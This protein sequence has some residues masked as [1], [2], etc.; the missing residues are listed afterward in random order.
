M[1]ARDIEKGIVDS[2]AHLGWESFKEDRDDVIKRAFDQGISQIV[3]AGVDFVS[4]PECLEIAE[5]YANI[6]NGVGLHPHEAKHWNADSA[7]VVRDAFR[8]PSVVAI[9]ECGLDYFYNHSE[10][11][12]QLQVFR[13]QV[14]L[15]REL[16]K[17]LIIHTRDAW[18][19]TFQ[20]IH[21]EGK[22]EVKGVFHCFTGGPA[23]MP[24][25]E[26]IDFY[27]SFSGIVTFK[28]SADIQAAAPMVKPSRI[29]VETDSPYLAPEGKRGKRNEPSF[30]WITAQKLATLRATDLSEIAEQTSENA[31][32]LFS[33][34]SPALGASP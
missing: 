32:R 27:V 9:G 1:E 11:E 8:H 30:V 2:H 33:L 21:E 4:L 34:P 15:C 25:I 7:D 31:R 13:E 28:K 29:L 12:T 26:R 17:P 5:K 16:N 18:D 10:R 3:Q 19:D 20:I 6:F 22:G 24:E 14:R 23:Q